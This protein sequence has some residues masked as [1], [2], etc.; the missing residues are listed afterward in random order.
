MFMD[1]WQLTCHWVSDAIDGKAAFTAVS[2]FLSPSPPYITTPV[3]KVWHAPHDDISSFRNLSL[4][5]LSSWLR[6]R[7]SIEDDVIIVLLRS[8]PSHRCS[9]GVV[10][11]L[12][13]VYELLIYFRDRSFHTFTQCQKLKIEAWASSVWLNFKSCCVFK[14]PSTK[15]YLWMGRKKPEGL[16]ALVAA[17]VTEPSHRCVCNLELSPSLTSRLAITQELWC[18]T[19]SNVLI[20]KLAYHIFAELF[21]EICPKR[22]WTQ[23]HQCRGHGHLR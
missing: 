13:N 14:A 1:R 6:T 16:W 5:F 3:R 19:C 23:W 15:K 7:L 2:P 18:L 22:D 10:C 11:I 21:Q 8:A 12:I 20:C 17:C 9:S 4:T